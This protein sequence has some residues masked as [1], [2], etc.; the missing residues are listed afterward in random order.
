LESQRSEDKRQTGIAAKERKEGIAAK[1]HKK[2]KKNTKKVGDRIQGNRDY[3]PKAR[4][5][6]SDILTASYVALFAIFVLF[7]RLFHSYLNVA[8]L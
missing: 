7:L 5:R 4:I 1:R 6:I 3:R 2:R 8:G